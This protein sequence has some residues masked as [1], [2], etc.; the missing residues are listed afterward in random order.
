MMKLSHFKYKKKKKT[1][2]EL[3]KQ[4]TVHKFIDIKTHNRYFSVCTI[5]VKVLLIVNL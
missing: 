5:T 4:E 2:K 3:Q 1:I